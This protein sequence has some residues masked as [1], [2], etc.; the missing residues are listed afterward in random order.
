MDSRID[1]KMF[2]NLRVPLPPRVKSFEFFHLI[3]REIVQI[4]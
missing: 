1:L 4:L 2:K 3:E